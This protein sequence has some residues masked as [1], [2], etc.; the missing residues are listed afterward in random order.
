MAVL[1]NLRHLEKGPV[2]R[3]GELTPAELELEGV[4]ELITVEGPVRYEFEAQKVED[5][6]LVRGRLAANLRCECARCLKP[7]IR[8][9]EIDDWACLLALEGEEKAVV[10]NDCLDLTP[11]LRED[12]LLEFPQHPLC[13]TGC[14]GLPKKRAGKTKKTGGAGQTKGISS[15][16]AVLNKLKF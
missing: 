11:Y 3:N 4:D 5:G 1:V 12:I 15:D 2:R 14:G 8:A 13:Q 16:W 9:L 7:F 6:V 10:S